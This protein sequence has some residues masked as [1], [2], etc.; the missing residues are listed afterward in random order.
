VVVRVRVTTMRLARGHRWPLLFATAL[1]AITV[2]TTPA[3]CASSS[4]F[5]SPNP[6]SQFTTQG[7]DPAAARFFSLLSA[8]AMREIAPTTY[9]D[10][11]SPSGLP[12][13]ALS[14]ALGGSEVGPMPETLGSAPAVKA[15]I[16]EALS[17]NGEQ[18]AVDS[19]RAAPTFRRAPFGGIQP[20]CGGDDQLPVRPPAGGNFWTSQ[21][22]SASPVQFPPGVFTGSVKNVLGDPI[23]GPAGHPTNV[24]SPNTAAGGWCRPLPVPLWERSPLASRSFWIPISIL[25]V[26]VVVFWLSRGVKMPTLPA[27]HFNHASC[28][29]P[30]ILANR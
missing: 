29:T 24:R 6:A 16:Y 30:K 15:L 4:A 28:Q 27:K 19:S 8:G 9:G 12:L 1:V 14:P 11:A 21:G 20:V 7:F 2:L 17:G 18:F 25:A 23:F 13:P 5:G 22:M 3:H 26:G 10:F